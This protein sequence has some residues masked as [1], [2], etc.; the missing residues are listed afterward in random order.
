MFISQQEEEEG[1]GV[2]SKTTEKELQLNYY[3]M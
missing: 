2:P 3:I 1:G